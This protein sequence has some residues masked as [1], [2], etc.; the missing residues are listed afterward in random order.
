MNPW[1]SRRQNMKE[2]N[3]NIFGRFASDFFSFDRHGQNMIRIINRRRRR[4]YECVEIRFIMCVWNWL[5]FWRARK[6]ERKK[7]GKI[8]QMGVDCESLRFTLG[9]LLII[10]V[11]GHLKALKDTLVNFHIC[12]GG[13]NHPKKFNCNK[14][15]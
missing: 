9:N 15:V 13:S 11:I 8:D 14:S 3:V 1:R 12:F 10:I 7:V 4:Q 6:Q 5:W 2:T